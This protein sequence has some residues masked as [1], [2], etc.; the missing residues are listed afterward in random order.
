MGF[1]WRGYYYR[2]RK[3]DGR[4]EREYIGRGEVAA[5][6][7]QMDELDRERKALGRVQKRAQRDEAETLDE[8]LTEL[9]ELTELLAHAALLAAG[10]H[11]HKRGEWRKKRDRIQ[12]S[13]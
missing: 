7:A 9:N 2:A 5:L 13:A 10:Y 12:E 1:D 11:R 8:P 4:V 3:V 6:A